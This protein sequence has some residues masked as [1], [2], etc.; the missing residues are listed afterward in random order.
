MANYKIKQNE[1]DNGIFEMLRLKCV[2]LGYLPNY[3]QYNN[4]TAYNN[5]KAA[6][7]TSGKQIIEVFG[8]GSA[9]SKGELNVN[10]II[11]RRASPKPAKTGVGK[12]FEYEKNNAGGYDKVETADSKYDIP[13]TITYVTTTAEYSDIIED[14][15]RA[16]FGIRRLIN[17][18][19]NNESIAGVFWVRYTG[20]AEMSDEK[21]IEKMVKYDAVNIDLDGSKNLGTV[22]ALSTF[23][24]SNTFINTQTPANAVPPSNDFSIE[25][26][27]ESNTP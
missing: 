12:S 8:V 23:V 11:I 18:I 6:I 15:I 5:A 19:S 7:R 25:I 16:C 14:I 13:Y 2:E 27:V 17:A 26:E 24:F 3:L 9:L 20:E 10:N 4:Q 22:A 1:V 21:F